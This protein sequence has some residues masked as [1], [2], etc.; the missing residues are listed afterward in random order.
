MQLTTFGNGGV[1][2]SGIIQSNQYSDPAVG[3]NTLAATGSTTQTTTSASTGVVDTNKGKV[4]GS[5]AGSITATTF[6]DAAIVGGG[7]GAASTAAALTGIGSF[8]GGFTA[9]PEPTITD[10]TP[11]ETQQ[12]FLPFIV[13][14]NPFAT[15]SS[16][17]DPAPGPTGGFGLASGAADLSA[18]GNIGAGDADVKALATGSLN[19]NSVLIATNGEGSASGSGS[20]TIAGSTGG[21]LSVESAST[22]LENEL[23]TG[24]ATYGS[25][26]FGAPATV[27]LP[28]SPV[29]IPSLP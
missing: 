21:S 25:G 22:G 15:T 16:T 4:N 3:G 20:G 19:F 18:G 11:D 27:T 24:F 13:L 17:T 7:G 23:V 10:T 26:F 28:N 5:T 9:V 2:G 29:G 14:A 8:G 6:S 1:R 12:P